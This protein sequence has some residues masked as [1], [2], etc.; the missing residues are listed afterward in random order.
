MVIKGKLHE[1]FPEKKFK[2][3]FRKREFIIESSEN[4]QYPQFLKFELLQDNCEMIDNF[5]IGDELEISFDLS[6]KSWTN[7]EG[8]KVYFNS[9]RVWKIQKANGENPGNN[10][11]DEF[12]QPGGEDLPF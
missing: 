4:A 2:D 8:E 5:S 6:G 9:L 7:P 11:L 3:T 1:V 12:L 10:P